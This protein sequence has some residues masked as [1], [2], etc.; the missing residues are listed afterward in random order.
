MD[1]EV[2]EWLL[3]EYTNHRW[4]SQHIPKSKK[5]SHASSSMASPSHHTTLRR[6]SRASRH[7][8]ADAA[9]MQIVHDW[10]YEAIGRSD[11]ELL[12]HCFLMFQ[13]MGV[14]ETLEINV[15][16]FRAFLIRIR[17]QYHSNPYHNFEHAVCVLQSAYK[18]CLEVWHM[19][20]CL[21]LL[22]LLLSLCLLKR[23]ISSIPPCHLSPLF[24]SPLI[25]SILS[26]YHLFY[27][28][29]HPPSRHVPG[30]VRGLQ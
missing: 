8:Q 16:A 26:F 21:C 28:Y 23:A 5:P 2:R 4:R 27:T 30:H 11:D 19:Q 10:D 9:A 15:T 22:P 18:L 3:E 7:W 20:S 14:L 6:S 1:S 13:D 12:Q 17:E 29:T 24:F 25:S